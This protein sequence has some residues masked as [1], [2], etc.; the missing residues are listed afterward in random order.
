MGLALCRCPSPEWV[1]G[2]A[3]RVVPMSVP[4]G[5]QEAHVTFAHRMTVTQ[6]ASSLSERLARAVP[7]T[8][9]Q[10]ADNDSL[11]AVARFS[12]MRR[13]ACFSRQPHRG[14]VFSLLRR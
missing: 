12:L 5:S 11:T 13:T 4:E 3:G 8:L 1:V 10:P 2:G 14:Q 6:I 9:Q 7:G